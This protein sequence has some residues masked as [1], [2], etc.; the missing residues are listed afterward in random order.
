[1]SIFLMGCYDKESKQW[2]TVTKVHTG[3]DE[4][5]LDKLQGELQP[6]MVKIKGDY[7]KVPLWLNCTRQMAPDFVA[8]DPKKSPVW[9]I[10][11]AEFTKAEIHTA[12]GISIRFP[13]ITRRRDDKDWKTA[14]DLEH[15]KALFKASKEANDFDIEYSSKDDAEV[16]EKEDVK[17]A[18]KDEPDNAYDE[19]TD[20]DDDDEEDGKVEP[21]VERSV[22]NGRSYNKTR[23]SGPNGLELKVVT[24]DL[25]S[26]GKTVSLAHC[27]SRDCR[28]G[29]GIAKLFRDKFGRV[30]EIEAMKAG[31]GEVAP[32]KIGDGVYIY[33]L[34]TKVK[35]SD[36][37][38][39]ESLENSLVSMREHATENKIKEIAMPKIG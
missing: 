26:A 22:T 34:V 31:V 5:T 19:D 17:V 2:C 8:K 9:E 30:K 27:I 24:G 23:I 21:R 25:F 33:N 38:T 11:G 37:P 16:G 29:K 6:N 4:A 35:Y 32:L 39:Y 18:V 12:D 14:T 10:S 36:K 1:M 3:V 28:L 13:R 15:L 20:A 7:S